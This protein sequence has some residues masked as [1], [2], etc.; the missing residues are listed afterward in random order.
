MQEEGRH[1][2]FFITILPSEHNGLDS[3]V[4]YQVHKVVF[5]IGS[6]K[7]NQCSQP[8]VKLCGNATCCSLEK[9]IE[10]VYTGKIRDFEKLS[11]TEIVDLNYLS[12]ALDVRI[13]NF[14]ASNLGSRLS[15][16]ISI[17]QEPNANFYIWSIVP[18]NGEC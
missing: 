6:S 5:A 13:G 14:L 2:D 17:V 9:L 1:C 7:I 8:G 10:Y 12:L 15:N 4:T 3:L 11:R 18:G 16:K